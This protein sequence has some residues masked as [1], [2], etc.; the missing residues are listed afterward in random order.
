[1]L[2]L[3]FI[4]MESLSESKQTSGYGVDLQ[5]NLIE[6]RWESREVVVVEEKDELRAHV[7]EKKSRESKKKSSRN[8][9]RMEEATREGGEVTVK[10]GS[11]DMDV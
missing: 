7:V 6:E 1:M 5:T 9:F 3:M 8:E 11:Q 4:E 10:L 2:G